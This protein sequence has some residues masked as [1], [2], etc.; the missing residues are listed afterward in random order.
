MVMVAFLPLPS[1]A[2]AVILTVP[3]FFPVTLPLAVTFATFGLLEVHVPDFL[4][5]IV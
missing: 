4:N 5:T 3:F 2:F 1:F